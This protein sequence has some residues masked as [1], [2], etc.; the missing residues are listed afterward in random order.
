MGLLWAS[1]NLRPL[2]V[3]LGGPCRLGACKRRDPFGGA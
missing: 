1:E 2:E 3:A